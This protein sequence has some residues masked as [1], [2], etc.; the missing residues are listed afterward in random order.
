MSDGAL[1]IEDVMENNDTWSND[2]LMLLKMQI[3]HDYKKKISPLISNVGT[4]TQ[5]RI[6]RWFKACANIRLICIYYKY[7][8]I[9]T[10]W[11]WEKDEVLSMCFF[12]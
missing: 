1:N 10:F 11:S 12:S 9:F 5:F 3:E 6:P 2:K 7:A 8:H 4:G